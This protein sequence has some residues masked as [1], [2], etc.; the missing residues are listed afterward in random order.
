MPLS[1]FTR[2]LATVIV[3][4]FALFLLWPDDDAHEY[5]LRAAATLPL[6]L[7]VF[8]WSAVRDAA[9][10]D[11]RSFHRTLPP[12]DDVAFRRVAGIH[13]LLLVGIA[14]AAIAYGATFNLGWRASS[15]ASFLL[16]VPVLGWMG[17]MGVVSSLGTSSEHGKIWGHLAI[18]AP[19]AFSWSGLKWFQ[20]VFEPASSPSI[21]PMLPWTALVAAFLYPPVWWLVAAKRRRALGMILGGWIGIV[22]LWPPELGTM[23]GQ[24]GT[25]SH[26]ERYQQWEASPEGAG[27]KPTIKRRAFPPEGPRWIPLDQLLEIEN[28]AEG[29]FVGLNGF[30][31]EDQTLPMISLPV[32]RSGSGLP[33]HRWSDQ[34]TAGRRNGRIVWGERSLWEA[35]A[36]QLA[37][38]ESLEG[39][40][41]GNRGESR[42]H[43]LN[44]GASP[45]EWIEDWPAEDRALLE[46]FREFP[47]DKYAHVP[48]KAWMGN[49]R[50]WEKL[51]DFEV[52]KGGS[53]RLPEG[54]ILRVSPLELATDQNIIAF[55]RYSP[56]L[57][58][59]D[60]IH[61]DPVESS[62]TVFNYP[63]ALLVD[64]TG[65]RVF[66]VDSLDLDATEHQLVADRTRWTFDAGPADTDE[67][68][69]RIE[70]LRRARIHVFWPVITGRS[71]A[72]SLPPP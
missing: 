64:E 28:L 63:R 21:I 31:T 6:L 66:A 40:N 7:G 19:I 49:P 8:T 47:T 55:Q 12:R 45:D 22:L 10:F 44:P 9:P 52:S 38:H 24:L 29:E 51:G 48:W 71:Q 58:H 3:A 25:K 20:S 41:I 43:I 67:N 32:V 57:H 37:P 34:L 70:M 56:N 18:F 54:G 26:F 1:P 68:V 17:L 11:E 72:L 60:G 35:L 50:R 30:V 13:A 5:G 65:K 42:P 23:L 4:L 36:E 16:V 33:M 46:R 62:E 59:I 14:L 39:W 53:V 15:F 27:T 61:L 2:F 69:R